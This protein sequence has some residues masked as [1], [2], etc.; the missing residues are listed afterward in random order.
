MVYNKNNN[1]KETKR[2]RTNKQAR[3]K[4][5]KAIGESDSANQMYCLS[6][7]SFLVSKV[8]EQEK[9]RKGSIIRIQY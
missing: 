5:R 4:K 6:C 7:Y 3:E 1:K 8:R 9:T 2:T